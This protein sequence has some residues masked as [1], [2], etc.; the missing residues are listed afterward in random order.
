MGNAPP[1]LNDPPCL[2]ALSSALDSAKAERNLLHK[3]NI[4]E[5]LDRLVMGDPVS[6]LVTPPLV[7]GIGAAP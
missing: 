3:V 5:P 6:E 2:N 1:A 7:P 4:S